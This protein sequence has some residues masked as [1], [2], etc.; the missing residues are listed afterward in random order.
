MSTGRQKRNNVS[1]IVTLKP[2]RPPCW[3]DFLPDGTMKTHWPCSQQSVTLSVSKEVVD[4]TPIASQQRQQQGQ[5]HYQQQQQQQNYQQH[6]QQL[7][8]SM[9]NMTITGGSDSCSGMRRLFHHRKHKN[10]LHRTRS[11]CN[12]E[13][14]QL[15]NLV[16]T[17]S[18]SKRLES[19]SPTNC[20]SNNNSGN[21]QTVTSGDGGGD[22]K[23]LVE[24]AK[25]CEL[26]LETVLATNGK[27]DDVFT[28]GSGDELEIPEENWR[29]LERFQK[30]ST[31]SS[32][33]DSAS[34]ISF[35]RPTRIA[36]K[37][38]TVK[39]TF[40]KP[41]VTNHSSSSITSHSNKRV[42]NHSDSTS[43]RSNDL[44]TQLE[45]VLESSLTV[46]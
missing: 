44:D 12:I 29:D 38:R 37:K 22:R 45:T 7:L 39:Q 42:T 26:W 6:Q 41:T 23:Y 16:E 18:D 15:P 5:T 30:S 2:P 1:N 43:P 36:R 13:T 8:T 33:I 4:A 24:N 40:S 46:C 28:Q 9:E 19:L 14:S 31:S 10:R 35:T 32:D 27:F 21:Q 34:T 3:R 25:R 17:L 11:Q 20:Y